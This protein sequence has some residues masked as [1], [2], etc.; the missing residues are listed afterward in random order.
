LLGNA[1]LE[2][3]VHAKKGE[4]LLHIVADLLDGTLVELPVVAVVV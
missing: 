2:V 1:I 3:C 4:L